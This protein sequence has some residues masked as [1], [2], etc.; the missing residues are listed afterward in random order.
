VLRAQSADE[1]EIR[2]VVQKFFAALQKKD[3]ETL[4]SLWGEKSEGGP[5]T[6]Q[7]SQPT[8]DGLGDVDQGSLSI[9]RVS[10]SQG[11][12]TGWVSVK[13]RA[14]D[15][16]IEKPEA[17]VPTN[18]TLHLSKEGGAWKVVKYGSSEEELANAIAA[19]KSDEERQ[20]LIEVHKELITLQ[21]GKAL[22]A[23]GAKLIDQGD[24][25]Q[26]LGLYQIISQVADRTKSRA[27]VAAVSQSV[28]LIR[29]NQ[30]DYRAASEKYQES[31]KAYDEAGMHDRAAG[32]LN[33][34][35]L[36]HKVQGDYDEALKYYE[37]SLEIYRNIGSRKGAAGE[38]V[39]IGNVH[40]AQA[41]YPRALE[42]F[43]EAL[44]ITKDIGDRQTLATVLLQIGQNHYYQTR[45]PEALSSF[46]EALEI[47][48][49]LGLKP[50]IAIARQGIGA[51]MAAQG[52]YPGALEQ[53]QESLR[54]E[55]ALGSKLSISRSLNGIAALQDRLG[56]Y[57]QALRYYDRALQIDEELHD[58]AAAAGVLNN[59]G[60]LYKSQGNYLQSLKYLEKSLASA[61]EAGERQVV[62]RALI[63]IGDLQRE[64]G[65]LTEARKCY[66]ESLKIAEEIGNQ[67]SI[68][69]SLTGLGGTEEATANYAQA[70]A[71]LMRSLDIYEQIGMKQF[72]ASTL[73]H[74]GHI[75]SLQ[76]AY[77]QAVESEER[78][79]EIARQIRAPELLIQV[80]TEA[81]NAY[82][83]TSKPGQ[84][85]KSFLEA[86][87]KVEQLRGL[88]A[89]SEQERQGFLEQQ[90]APY[91]AMARLMMDQ[92]GP[93]EALTY[94]ER[95]K[96]R[97]LIDVLASGRGSLTKASTAEER[98]QEQT[99]SSRLVS[100]NAQI[101]NERV[102]KN[103]DEKRVADLTTQLEKARL[104]YE[105]FRTSL[106]AAH[107]ELKIQR[108]EFQPISLGECGGLL[109]DQS[110][111]LL[112][113]AVSDDQTYLFVLTKKNSSQTLPDLK[114]Y[115][116]DIKSKDLTDLCT[117]FHEQLS[118]HGLDFDSL[119][120]KLYSLLLGP[121]S[122]EL[123]SRTN[124]VI[125]ADGPLW[126]LP[127][128]ALEPSRRHYLIERYA[129]SY[130]PSLTALREMSRRADNS[131]G[132]AARPQTLLALGNPALSTQT[133]SEIKEA[134]MD[135][136]LAP[137]PQAEAQVRELA[138]L[139]GLDHSKIYTGAEATEDRLKAEAPAARVL[140]IA[141][142]GIVNDASP[143]Y[144]QL[145]LSRGAGSQDD[146]LLEAWEIMN[147]D[148]KADLVV[149]AACDTAGGRYG[150]GEGMIGLSWAFFIAGC[151]TTV[152]SQWKVEAESTSRLMVAFH[153]NLRSGLTTAEA[154]RRAELKL[155]K[156]EPRYRDP[157]YWAP[158]VV[159]GAGN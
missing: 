83:A 17:P 99:L 81:G 50:R 24:Y 98:S 97:A 155:L 75:L 156:S 128:Q 82:R 135:A 36:L 11:E 18:L 40:M 154:L 88:V 74:I 127:F 118:Q 62:A 125:V 120:R 126:G 121:A 84:A 159:I 30:G 119:A 64:R 68:S 133:T 34:I 86:I 73:G 32:V 129:V 143:L 14:R 27:I 47:L 130:A 48:V 94:T 72:I 149:L 46:K 93:F 77:A 136:D 65:D 25:P 26:A 138:K 141:A 35:G 70:L 5:S 142:H 148:L 115:K 151:P 80:L 16:K 8:I 123:Q 7:N 131:S 147:M 76:G 146:G 53:F 137:L 12:A 60:A 23:I 79:A 44:K 85:R 51:V 144:S 152:V 122:A 145:V 3:L 112:E 67:E 63:N 105:A 66:Q 31:L 103:P 104:D 150:A 49:D 37:R 90:I 111:A 10:V 56:N 110:T 157:F 55:D 22:L 69:G 38:L 139:Y 41:D 134:F 96:A 1:S 116:I 101:V 153:H 6:K 132:N 39:N 4:K 45:Y 109:P 29:F 42:S 28:G 9:N 54:I 117:R 15:S 2:L 20:T 33:N 92:N 107:P 95:A 61:R 43:E 114:A 78:A 108:A 91:Y 13:I 59:I 102:S 89:G 158:F 87:D 21:L 106:Y 52:N 113:F 100:L 124:L 71:Y 140:H 58:K 19:A 57:S